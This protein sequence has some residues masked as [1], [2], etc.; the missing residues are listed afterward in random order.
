MRSGRH[1]STGGVKGNIAEQYKLCLCDPFPR[2]WQMGH[3]KV[4]SKGNCTLSSKWSRTYLYLAFLRKQAYLI[5]SFG[6]QGCC[7]L[8]DLKAPESQS[9]MKEASGFKSLTAAQY[10]SQLGSPGWR[11][12]SLPQIKWIRRKWHHWKC[13]TQ[14]LKVGHLRFGSRLG[15]LPG[16]AFGRHPFPTEQPEL[17][18]AENNSHWELKGQTYQNQASHLLCEKQGW[19]SFLCSEMTH[20]PFPIL[21]RP[22]LPGSRDD[23]FPEFLRIVL[24]TTPQVVKLPRQH[25][26]K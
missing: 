19:L 5:N 25:M 24:E 16:L 2:Y 1:N 18:E 8:F 11:Q 14:L 6:I 21:L 23:A 20:S 22:K 10:A 3:Q 26:R 13:Q 9:Q 15:K 4:S 17:S 12:M 7:G